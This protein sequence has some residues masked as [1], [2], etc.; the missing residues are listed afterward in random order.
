M[1]QV[2]LRTKCLLLVFVAPPIAWALS[3]VT[4]FYVHPWLGVVSL[5]ATGLG[6]AQL[7][8]ELRCPRCGLRLY[9]T[10][11]EIFLSGVMKP[12]SPGYLARRCPHCRGSLSAGVSE[13]EGTR[14]ERDSR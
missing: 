5:F 2:T 12:L 6:I 3:L 8:A 4:M 10:L 7:R 1:N 11:R 14:V 9:N 13:V